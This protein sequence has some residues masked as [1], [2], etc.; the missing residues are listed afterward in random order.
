[1]AINCLNGFAF[2]A[3][4]A[5][6]SL[7]LDAQNQ[8]W[9]I[10]AA[11]GETRS[12]D[13]VTTEATWSS[14]DISAD[15][16]WL[17][18]DMLGH[19]YR[20]SVEGGE[21][22]CLTQDSGIALNFHP[23]ISPDGEA[24]AFISDRGGQDN[25]WLMEADGSSPR[26]VFLDEN[27]RATEP[28]WGPDGQEIYITR[29]MK[30]AFGFYRVDDA[31]WAY[32]REGGAGK[33][34]VG[35]KDEGGE[36]MGAP[37]N[38]RQITTGHLRYQWSSP[39]P[40][41]RH[42]YFNIATFDG[43]DKH[44]QR[45]DLQDGT[46]E[47]IT[48]SKRRHHHGLGADISRFDRLGS[49]APE[50]SPDGRWLA[51][52]RKIPAG[53]IS[54][55]GIEYEGRTALWLRDL[56]SGEERLLMDPIEI[57][58]MAGHPT[59]KLRALPGYSWASD[60]G[61]IVICQGG[62]IRRKWID[63]GLIETI[64]FTA[65]VRREIS[66]MARGRVVLDDE[67]FVARAARWPAVSPDGGR[68]VFAAAGRLW[69]KTLGGGAPQALPRALLP[70]SHVL[71][72]TPAWS[73]DGRWIVWVS[74]DNQE[75][76]HV[77]K[78]DLETGERIRLTR[79]AGRY[80]H[81]SWSPDGTS[82][83]FN[84]WPKAL[85]FDPGAT[86]WQLVS[87]PTEV[88]DP[89]PD[90]G[91]ELAIIRQGMRL[92]SPGY[93]PDGRIYYRRPSGPGQSTLSS[94]DAAGSDD[95]DHLQ[96][97]GPLPEARISPDGEHVAVQRARD[98]YI[99]PLVAGGEVQE[100]D[101]I[102]ATPASLIRVSTQGGYFPHWIDSNRLGYFLGA[103]HN[104]YDLAAG[105]LRAGSLDLQIPR[106]T[107]RGKLALTNARILTMAGGDLDVIEQG[108]IIIDGARIEC[109][110]RCSPDAVDRVIDMTG[111]TIT[112]GWIDTHAHNQGAY[113]SAVDAVGMNPMQR[114]ASAAYLAFGVT[115]AFDPSTSDRSFAIGE[116]TAAGK[117]T[118]PRSFN[119][120]PSLTCDW[121]NRINIYGE[122]DDHRHI[123]EYQ[124]ALRDV[125][126][127]AALGAISIKDYKQCTRT[128]R[129]MLAAAARQT[130]VSLT[131]ENGDMMYILGQVMNGHTGW[132]H[133]LQYRPI[134]SDVSRFF[135]QAGGHY[136]SDLF[137]S[138][139]PP[140]Q[141]IDYWYA[142]SDLLKDKKLLY[143]LPEADLAARRTFMKRPVSQYS[144]PI[145]AAG[146]WDM[147]QQGARPTIGAHGEL[148][149]KSAHF[150]VWLQ[151]FAAPPLEA[152]RYA[153]ING[154]HF[155]GLYNELGSI[156]TGKLADLVILSANPLDNIRNTTDIAWVMK[157]GRLY[158]AN[159]LD[160]HWPA[161]RAYGPRPWVSVT[162]GLSDTRTVE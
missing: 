40:D 67:S 140:G 117:I 73:P 52:A 32:P 17:V 59:W 94:I 118:G 119:S 61:S 72:R 18:F 127:Q 26:A 104:I 146:T 112:P 15:G 99:V 22:V 55:R 148:H 57:D 85:D 13:F 63:S 150:E 2:A 158:D 95:R 87:I 16:N 35:R 51:F 53:I 149:G 141:A 79:T 44:I 132:E 47:S 125:S 157:G 107:V 78:V 97:Q 162:T 38:E 5:T 68:L 48:R 134:Y 101:V 34:I 6:I 74:A 102:A 121:D 64:P 41:G 128:Q 106:N 36:V 56:A 29:R 50:V 161:Q 82:I 20:V 98:I 151:A 144:F 110:G 28:A 33:H 92:L 145:L 43:D 160:E 69:L 115:T 120:G 124:D 126:R 103:S 66:E 11:R 54:F 19:I 3:L 122:G 24:I 27:S 152:I 39:S 49:I 81:P 100:I 65:R 138:D 9:Q 25:L 114:S 143:W 135:G 31:I 30:T 129:Q 4:L 156:E 88:G 83:A 71:E 133:P 58:A 21:A 154:A 1:M 7:P 76:A 8:A 147:A 91:S 75:R 123:Y 142:D 130:G 45:I 84:A 155:L 111:K 42:V 96:F 108:V 131:T 80:L 90:P 37:A 105:Q 77:W 153:T 109:V 113:D 60:S 10:G 23:R 46:V 116:L 93:G 86:H 12:I 89:G 14:V 139:Y 159:T 137:I 136:S 62:K 70:D